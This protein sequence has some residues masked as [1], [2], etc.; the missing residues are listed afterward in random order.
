MSAELG[1]YLA[2]ENSQAEDD[3]WLMTLVYDGNTMSLSCT[4]LKLP[5]CPSAPV[6]QIQLPQ[7]VPIGFHG[8]WVAD[9]SV[10][11]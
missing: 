6:A 9:S 10:A 1:C 4:F 5:T 2:R 11:P 3:G 7:R 8:N